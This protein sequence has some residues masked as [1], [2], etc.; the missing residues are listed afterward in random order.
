MSAIDSLCRLFLHMR[1]GPLSVSD[2]SNSLWGWRVNVSMCIC[3]LSVEPVLRI[4]DY[5]RS[6]IKIGRDLCL[7]TRPI[8]SPCV[9]E[10][11]G[12]IWSIGKG[13]GE[14]GGIVSWGCTFRRTFCTLTTRIVGDSSL[15]SLTLRIHSWPRSVWD[16]MLSV[17]W[18]NMVCVSYKRSTGTAKRRRFLSDILTGLYLHVWA[19]HEISTYEW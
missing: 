4:K 2:Y 11:E 19:H 5:V 14:E 1:S 18:E 13:R 3:V 16:F 8:V 15:C 12:K 7:H 10:I 6:G 9:L 17:S